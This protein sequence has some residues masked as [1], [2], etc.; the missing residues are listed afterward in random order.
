MFMSTRIVRS[1]SPCYRRRIRL[2]DAGYVRAV[3]LGGNQSFARIDVEMS[4]RMILLS[5]VYTAE[6]MET[7][8]RPVNDV[9]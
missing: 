9:S 7:P 3:N 1:R 4:T 5:F 8:S 6:Q 2:R